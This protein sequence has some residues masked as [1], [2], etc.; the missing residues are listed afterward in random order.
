MHSEIPFE[1]QKDP[2]SFAVENMEQN[3]HNLGTVSEYI[4]QIV[5]AYN[6]FPDGKAEIYRIMR[7]AQ[8][9]TNQNVKTMGPEVY[10]VFNGAIL[11][12]ELASTLTI[13]NGSW[14]KTG[15]AH[16]FLESE[17][18]TERPK[19]TQRY[20]TVAEQQQRLSVES[21]T[22]RDL[23]SQ[24]INDDTDSLYETFGTKLT[25]MLYQEPTM[26]QLSMMGY[27]M[28]VGEVIQPSVFETSDEIDAFIGQFE[29]V[30][31][32]APVRESIAQSPISESEDESIPTSQELENI[33]HEPMNAEWEDK[34]SI[35]NIFMKLSNAYA[36]SEEG[37]LFSHSDYTN[38]CKAL[39]KQVEAFNA[40][41]NYLQKNDLLKVKGNFFAIMNSPEGKQY[42]DR[43][44]ELFEIS[45]FFSGFHVIPVPNRD[46][47]VKTINDDIKDPIIWDSL[48]KAF[49]PV[50]RLQDPA[51]TF[52]LSDSSIPST[53]ITH[54]H[55]IDIP[56]NYQ[57]LSLLKLPNETLEDEQ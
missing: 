54:G 35:Q 26:Q 57:T 51:F 47:L 14:Y 48:P 46:S 8:R 53:D 18:G 1:R 19:N 29:S 25:S 9:I 21:S 36:S 20:E 5:G 23:L 4:T 55:S 27:R 22:M 34:R 12:M 10:A 2:I 16:S 37:K 11:G 32:Y 24:P 28:I 6:S 49:A 42:L 41:Q 3:L 56:L 17:M 39:L 33:L 50:I 30:E 43:Q 52:R 31:T 7:A 38:F 15:Y 13:D 40:E 45:G 44:Y